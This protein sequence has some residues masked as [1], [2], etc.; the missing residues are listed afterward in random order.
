MIVI[1]IIF[2]DDGVRTVRACRHNRYV[3]FRPIPYQ[4]SWVHHDR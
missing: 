4:A 2:S 1:W 3:V